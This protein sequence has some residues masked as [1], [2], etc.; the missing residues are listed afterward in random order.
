VLARG[1]RSDRPGGRQWRRHRRARVSPLRGDR[2]ERLVLPTGC[3][4]A[5]AADRR[6]DLRMSFAM[7]ATA[8]WSTMT[9]RDGSSAF[10]PR[11]SRR[12]RSPRRFGPKET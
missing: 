6:S 3:A 10:G 4:H 8:R 12:E 7:R 9:P 2:V 11:I 5:C 1:A